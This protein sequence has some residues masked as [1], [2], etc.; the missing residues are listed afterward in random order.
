MR[1]HTA[2]GWGIGSPSV[3][4][5]RPPVDQVVGHRRAAHACAPWLRDLGPRM[6]AICTCTYSAFTDHLSHGALRLRRTIS[7]RAALDDNGIFTGAY[8]RAG[9]ATLSAP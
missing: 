3:A 8:D 2:P 1:T 7:P 6:A 4:A 9:S 5:I